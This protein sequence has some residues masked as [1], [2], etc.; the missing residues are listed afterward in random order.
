MFLD[1]FIDFE[2]IKK[3]NIFFQK[4]FYIYFEEVYDKMYNFDNY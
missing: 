2:S 3:E 4:K 1:N